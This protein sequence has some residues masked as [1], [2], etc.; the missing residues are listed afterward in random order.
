MTALRL[1]EHSSSVCVSLKTVIEGTQIITRANGFSHS[2]RT[3]LAGTQIKKQ[4]NT[5]TP[6]ILHA[7]FSG[8][9]IVTRIFI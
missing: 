9:P 6:E 8:I 5:Y 2:D 4:N 3:C 1:S 7:L